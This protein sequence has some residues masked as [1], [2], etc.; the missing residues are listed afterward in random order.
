VLPHFPVPNGE[1]PALIATGRVDAI[2]MTRD[3]PYRRIEY[4]RYLNA[5]YRLPLV[6]GTDKM[7]ASVPVGLI[8]T[9]VFIPPGEPFSYQTWCRNLAAG[10]SFVTTGPLLSL[11][12]EGCSI[13]DT[14]LLSLAGGTVAVEIHADGIFPIHRLELI[15][16]GQVVASVEAPAGQAGPALSLKTQLK[17]HQHT[18]LAAR[19]LGHPGPDGYDAWGRELMAHTSPVYIACGGD[20]SMFDPEASA[21]MLSM[22]EGSLAYLHSR[23]RY[24]PPGT[25]SHHHGEADHLAFLQRPFLQARTAIERRRERHAGG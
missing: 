10:R 16:A 18:W 3:E 17:I 7:D 9:Y 5:G 14:V 11:A 25:A 1:P 15:Q 19:C 22:I 20:W 12:V 21:Y 24:H 13:G 4:Y 23:P 6:G 8:R 2:E